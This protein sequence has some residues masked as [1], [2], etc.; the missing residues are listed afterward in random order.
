MGS[1][2]VTQGQGLSPRL[3]DAGFTFFQPHCF[4]HL[5]EQEQGKAAGLK[6][7]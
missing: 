4:T 1:R 3:E 5:S 6:G 2:T 7:S